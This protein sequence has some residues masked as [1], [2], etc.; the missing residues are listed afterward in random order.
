L[1]APPACW[2]W[3]EPH[4]PELQSLLQQ[5]GFVLQ[6]SPSGLHVAVDEAH[7]PAVHV[8]PQHSLPD[9]QLA[10]VALHED[11]PQVP[12]T[13]SLLQQ[14]G[15]ALHVE[16]MAPHDG[17]PHVPPVHCPSQQS[18]ALLQELPAAWQVGAAQEPAVHVALQQSLASE[19]PWPVV[20]HVSVVQ[21][22]PAHDWL[23]QSE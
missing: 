20:R 10:P 16:P 3:A 19:Q 15:L 12:D 17:A 13:Q 1:Q 22:P 5:S 7:A 23:Q 2:H 8:P 18:L 6:P 9:W 14:S 4:L 21:V 11:D